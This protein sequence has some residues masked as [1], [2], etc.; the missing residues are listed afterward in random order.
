MIACNAA[1]MA[2]EQPRTRRANELGPTG[3][4]VAANI[5]RIRNAVG[6]STA[7]LSARL[8]EL[9]RPIAASAI[10]KIEGGSRRVDVDDLMAIAVAFDV[11][12]A[13][14]CLPPSLDGSFLLLDGFGDTATTIWDWAEGVAPLR[15][16]P[17]DDGEYWNAFQTRA[18]PPGR[19]KYRQSS[20]ADAYMEAVQNPQSDASSRKRSVR[21]PAD[22]PTAQAAK[23]RRRESDPSAE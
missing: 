3:R 12:L 11:P 2:E 1:D 21:L 8:A 9:G 10:T 4:T 16:P 17:N 15:L 14:L 22:S 13:A 18:K 5:A 19:R 20:I 23:A 6:L 7:K